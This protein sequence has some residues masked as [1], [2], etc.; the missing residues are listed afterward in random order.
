MRSLVGALLL[1]CSSAA[2]AQVELLYIGA[3]DCGFCR[4]W[5]AQ[6]LQDRMPKASLDWA[7]VRFTMVDI[8]SFR[9]RFGVDNAPARLRPGMARA[10]EAAGQM[11]LRGTPW[12]ALFVDG[13]VR[14]HTFGVNS[15]ETRIKPAMLDAL[16]EKTKA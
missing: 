12:F 15:F 9:N 2:L 5:E 14:V 16:R 4:R 10:L 13:E 3:A 8:G 7:G 6:Y 11:S 1:A